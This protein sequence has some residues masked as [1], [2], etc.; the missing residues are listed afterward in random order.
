LAR[1]AQ[2]PPTAARLATRVKVKAMPASRGRPDLRKGRSE[3]AKT[4][5]RT[6]RMQ[7]LSMVRMPPR[8]AIANKSIEINILLFMRVREEGNSYEY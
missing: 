8:Y 4:K 1:T 3:R 5:G 6:G 7:G 2:P